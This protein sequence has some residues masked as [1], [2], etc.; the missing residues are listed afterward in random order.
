MK[1]IPVKISEI[2]IEREVLNSLPEFTCRKY[3]TI[4]V[5]KG[6]NKLVCGMVDPTDE[7]VI[8]ELEKITGMTVEPRLASDFEIK[9]ALDK[10]L[11][12]GH[13]EIISPVEK[14]K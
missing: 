9:E 5:Y 6:G 13:L 2:N 1:G 4:P 10:Y 12:Q 14:R 7:E 8:K 3:R 11:S